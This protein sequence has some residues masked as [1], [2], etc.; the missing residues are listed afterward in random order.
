M[1]YCSLSLQ[2]VGSDLQINSG[3]QNYLFTFLGCFISKIQEQSSVVHFFI[4]I[5]SHCKLYKLILIWCIPFVT[6]VLNSLFMHFGYPLKPVCCLFKTLFHAFSCIVVLHATEQQLAPSMLQ[7]PILQQ[8][9]LFL[10]LT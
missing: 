2:H 7:K 5:C 3:P 9:I 8:S 10:L 4:G 1:L 6:T